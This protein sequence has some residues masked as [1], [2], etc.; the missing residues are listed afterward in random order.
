MEKIIGQIVRNSD[1]QLGEDD[2]KEKV[3][4]YVDDIKEKRYDFSSSSK[5]I[6][7]QGKKKRVIYSFNSDSTESVICKYLKKKIGLYFSYKISKQ[8]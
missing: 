7:T 2:I 1:F 8:E 3:K 5:E 4:H 6:Y